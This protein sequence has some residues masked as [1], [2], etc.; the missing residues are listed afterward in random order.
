MTEIVQ[1]VKNPLALVALGMVLLFAL[2]RLDRKKHPWLTGALV[3]LMAVS[4]VGGILLQVGARPSGPATEMKGGQQA[5]VVGPA[6]TIIGDNKGDINVNVVDG[7]GMWFALV[8]IVVIVIGG[9][10]VALVLFRRGKP[11]A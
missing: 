4:I 2:W 8:A 5:I 10:V 3:T 7:G 6:G 9:L 1:A 11:P